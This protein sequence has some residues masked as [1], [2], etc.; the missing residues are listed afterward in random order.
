MSV[1]TRTTRRIAKGTVISA[2]G[3]AVALGSTACSSGKISQT[4]NQDAAVNGAFGSLALDPPEREGDQAVLPGSIAVRNV[5]IMYPSDKASEVFGDG[6]PFQVVFSIANDSVIRTVKLT[7]IT[8]E[9]GKVEFSA[10]GDSDSGSATPGDAGLIAPNNVLNAGVPAN[11][12]TA[13]AKKDG[14]DRINVELD[15]TGDTV[16][17][18]LTTPLTFHFEIYDLERDAN[19]KPR[20]APIDTKSVT[21]DTPVDGTSLDDRQDIV[22]DVQQARGDGG[23]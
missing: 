17:A 6:G 11:V 14:I 2:F 12:D 23:H 18:G 13:E 15:G 8:A 3:I 10:P 20:N 5:Q 4:N 7:G 16:A 21:I 19:G 9:Q 1:F 22:R